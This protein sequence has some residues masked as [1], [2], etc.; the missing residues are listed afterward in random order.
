MVDRDELNKALSV[1]PNSD[2]EVWYRV[3]AALKTGLGEDGL[4][5]WLQ[6]SY[7]PD[8][9][10]YK[11]STARSTWKSL[12]AGHIEIG[13]IFNRAKE[14]GYSH[15][16]EF[17][18][19]SREQI[20]S[21][22]QAA[23]AAKEQALAERKAEM[24]QAKA[25]AQE[26][27][28][29]LHPFSLHNLEY[30][31]LARKLIDDHSL[32]RQVRLDNPT[33]D[34]KT[35][36]YPNLIIPMKK[37][38]EIVGLQ[39]INQYGRKSFTKGMELKG[40]SLMIGSWANRNNGLVLAEGYA[41]AASIHKATGLTTIVCFAG[42]NLKEVAMRLP[43]NLDTQV[44][45]AADNDLPNK[46]TGRRAG[47][48]YAMAAKDVFGDKAIVLVPEFSQTDIDFFKKKYGDRPSDFNDL[49]LL[50]GVGAV[51]SQ[52]EKK[53]EVLIEQTD[54]REQEE[55]AMTQETT[56]TAAQTENDINVQENSIAPA[57]EKIIEQQADKAVKKTDKEQDDVTYK[58]KAVDPTAEQK[59]S[60]TPE[61]SINPE[62]QA[63]E[64]AAAEKIDIDKELSKAIVLDHDYD[65][66]P[67]ELK[68]KYLF[69]KNGEYIDKFGEVYF[70]DR[71]VQLKSPKEDR[72]TVNDMLE[73]AK[74][75]GW[76]SINLT[77]TKEFR[78]VAYIEAVSRGIEAYGYKPTERDLTIIEQLRDEKSINTINNTEL[79]KDKERIV[80][81]SRE[82]TTKETVEVS[83]FK[84][85]LLDHGEANYKFDEK[86][87][88]SYF[89]YLED[90]NGNK[91]T[92]WG[93][94]L[95]TAINDANVKLNDNVVL[96]NHGRQAVQVE[97]K[98]YDKNG[99]FTHTE[100]IDAYRN[101]WEVT[102][103]KELSE[104]IV[105]RSPTAQQEAE[106][107]KIVNQNRAPSEAVIED[108]ARVDEHGADIP[109]AGVGGQVIQ[110]ELRAF[111]NGLTTKQQ[112]LNK[113]S[114]M[115]L[116]MAKELV[117]GVISG[118]SK[119]HQNLAIKNFNEK[120]D[121]RINGQTLTLIPEHEQDRPARTPTREHD[122][123]AELER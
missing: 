98:V 43:K 72:V 95:E 117:K 71:G 65:H 94:E 101:K 80:A 25:E 118:L 32:L 14:Y 121:E 24:D 48:D 58:T 17:T 97:Q 60:D 16:K 55:Q 113:S 74:E 76:S 15:S 28:A 1:I 11:E 75:K 123:E 35:G 83:P 104:E 44:I 59:R 84:G 45:I 3:G 92:H 78:R 115:T 68:A 106:K 38:G 19:P 49:E 111:M 5:T 62:Q 70:M 57:I 53:K 110:D 31:Y 122:R 33:I 93:K 29:S 54:E 99:N 30:P 100:V 2:R 61:K 82:E 120:I 39:E 64:K 4:D 87:S 112:G 66:P 85:K 67:S 73:V 6:W 26:K 96:I 90:E 86:N 63:T 114:L 21:Q 13:Y 27:Y 40:A 20:E 7:N 116:K 107:D 47:L 10:V 46:I 37:N 51:A 36:T 105:E 50:L 77:G 91:H 52:F 81:A 41:T 89:V 8:P 108:S 9:H 12:R 119:E 56:S 88:K 79:T 34:P 103:K 18:P 109:M 23:L 22:R 69:S 102:H 42:F